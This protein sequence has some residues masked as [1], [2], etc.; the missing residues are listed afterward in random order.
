MEKIFTSGLAKAIGLSN[1]TI[2]KTE[3]LLK[4]ANVVPAIN[5]VECHPY[6][7]QKKLRDYCANKGKCYNLDYHF[8]SRR[9]IIYH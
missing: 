5:Q 7:Q 9:I 1:F 2:T 6:F 8:I 4:T 3:A